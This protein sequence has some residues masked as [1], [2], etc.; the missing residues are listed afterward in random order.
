VCITS[1]EQLGPDA[2]HLV[3]EDNVRRAFDDDLFDI[4]AGFPG[5][6]RLY[7][8]L[9]AVG[10]LERNPDHCVVEGIQVYT[11]GI[12]CEKIRRAAETG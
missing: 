10:L 4:V 3:P 1:L 7:T 11:L 2:V 12:A 9:L 8:L 6:A 5:G